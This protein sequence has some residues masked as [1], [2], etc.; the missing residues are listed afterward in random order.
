MV[1]VPL[2]FSFSTLMIQGCNGLVGPAAAAASATVSPNRRQRVS[3]KLDVTQGTFYNNDDTA[4]EV[5][6]RSM[7]EKARELA[8]TSSRTIMDTTDEARTYLQSIVSLQKDCLVGTVSGDDLCNVDDDI[9]EI[10]FQLKEIISEG[11]RYVRTFRFILFCFVS[12]I[13][14]D[15]M[16]V[17]LFDS[18]SFFML[19]IYTVQRQLTW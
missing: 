14:F 6:Y 8:V 17:F 16:T 11:A 1:S 5:Y 4:S 7:L 18:R 12:S 2:L 19:T 9:A 3:S 15:K 10:V 13:F